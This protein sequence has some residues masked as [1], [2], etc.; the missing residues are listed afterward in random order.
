MFCITLHCF[1]MSL[2]FNFITTKVKLSQVGEGGNAK[3][4]ITNGFDYKLYYNIYNIKQQ[5]NNNNKRKLYKN[6]STY[7]LLNHPSGIIKQV[8]VRDLRQLKENYNGFNDCKKQIV[9]GLLSPP[10]L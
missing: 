6:K 10:P 7:V 2:R 1:R 5:Q 8:Y 9:L 3:K 4:N